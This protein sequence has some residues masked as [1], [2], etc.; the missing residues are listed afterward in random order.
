MEARPKPIPLNER[1]AIGTFFFMIKAFFESMMDPLYA[2]P[3]GAE[4]G[5][6]V[7][8]DTDDNPFAKRETDRGKTITVDEL[9]KLGGGKGKVMNIKSDGD[10]RTLLKTTGSKLVVVDF[11][12]TW[13]GPCKKIAPQFAELSGQYGSKVKFC[14]VDVDKNQ[15]LSQK[16]G[17]S[18]MPTFLFIKNGKQLD[19]LAG[20]GIDA[21]RQKITA[22]K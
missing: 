12:A 22:L 16:Y 11:F 21:I 10:F 7:A 3:V 15:A 8:S 5:E 6:A 1:S 9:D 20:A 2:M 17:V 19:K 14:K 13:C 18:S 4:D